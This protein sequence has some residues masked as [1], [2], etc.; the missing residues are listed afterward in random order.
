MKVRSILDTDLYLFSVSYYFIKQ[1]PEASGTLAFNDRNKTI[2]SNEDLKN[3]KIELEALKTLELS[4]DEFEW[5]KKKK[6]YPLYP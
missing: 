3:L 4:K 1:Y 6:K 5:C 2:Y